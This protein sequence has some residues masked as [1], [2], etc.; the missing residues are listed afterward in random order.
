VPT[1]LLVL[2]AVVEVVREF[3]LGTVEGLE[4]VVLSIVFGVGLRFGFESVA[5]KTSLVVSK[6]SPVSFTLYV[7]LGF[8]EVILMGFAVLLEI[9]GFGGWLK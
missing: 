3:L 9:L 6:G 2:F 7:S 4:T 5:L 8:W 1:R